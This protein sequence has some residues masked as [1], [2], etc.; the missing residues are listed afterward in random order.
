MDVL[1]CNIILVWFV[2]DLCV[3]LK[4]DGGL[5]VGSGVSGF[6]VVV[7]GVGM[8]YFMFL[9]V[10]DVVVIVVVFVKVVFIVFVN[11]D[12]LVLMVIW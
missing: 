6:V 8:S 9:V 7:I 10:G 5:L 3:E 12:N 4:C 2:M 11:L 1:I